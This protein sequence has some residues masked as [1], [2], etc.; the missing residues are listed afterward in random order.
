MQLR[1]ENILIVDDDVNILELLQRH[2][3]SWH[4]H[5]FKAI[6]V[7]EAVSILRD[8]QID[9]LIT[10]LKMPEVDGFELIKF[11]S[12]HYP[13]LPKLVVTGYPSIQDSLAAIKSGVVDYLTKPFTKDELKTAIDKS[14][15]ASQK[16][17]TKEDSHKEVNTKAYGDII[18]NSEK[19]NDVIQV[20]ERIKDNKA[21]I[22]IKGESGTGKELVARAIHYQGKFSRAPFVAVNCG[23]I[24]ENLLEAELF[25]Y[26][27]GA[28]TGA[29][30]N[31][32]GFFQA[33]DGGTIFLDEI[34]NASLPVQSRLLRVLQ[35]KEVVRVGS[36]KAE[37]IDVRI[38][39]ATNSDLREMIKKQTF[40]EDLFYRL[41]VV[42]IEIAPLCER[43]EDIQLLV[44][45]FL[46]KYGVEYKD[47]FVKITPEALT[48]LER[49][50]W[51]GNVR[52]LEN[53]IQRAVIMCDKVIEVQ[54]L[55]E[56]LKYNLNF[57]SDELV[58]LRV[59]EKKYIQ[60]VLK[61]TDNNK[62]KAAEILQIDRKT[63]RQK[64]A[65][66]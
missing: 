7:K 47:R 35:E 61:A 29:E 55:P 9:L 53:I 27:K 5:V 57:P 39:A 62:S 43:K 12:E 25:G 65:D 17:P 18:G 40:R 58:P 22:F 21:T 42:E 54:H 45:K 46:F 49:Y 32:E 38:I 44:D 3:Q 63:I 48:I 50:E 16:A 14:M 34:G 24:P 52:E 19:I 10:D 11:V 26:L 1:K 28:F 23:A 36:T 2:L 8:T 13:K 30:T 60:K 37:K 15:V 4:Y 66:Q 41:T 20:I 51:P 64:L 6:S 33:A 59:M 31:R 56:H